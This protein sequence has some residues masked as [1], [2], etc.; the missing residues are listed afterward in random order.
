MSAIHTTRIDRREKYAKYAPALRWKVRELIGAGRSTCS[1]ARE[2]GVSKGVVSQ[3]RR[4][5]LWTTDDAPIEELL[6]SGV[7]ARCR[8]CLPAVSKRRR[9]V[10]VEFESRQ[11]SGDRGDRRF[12]GRRDRG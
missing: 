10:L 6:S 11:I 4:G 2:T 1:I 7:K 3:V 8:D 9:E 5:L 12:P